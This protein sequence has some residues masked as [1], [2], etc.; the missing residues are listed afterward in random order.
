MI[1]LMTDRIIL[2]PPERRELT[3][4]SRNRGARLED[5]RRAR[6]VLGLASGSAGLRE[7]ARREGC[8]VNTV[9]TWRDRFMESRLPGLFSRHRGRK[10]E[11]GSEKIEARIIDWTLHRKP[12]DGSTQWSSRKLATALGLNHVR[13]ARVWGKAGLQ[14][15]RRRH[16]MASDDPN[17]EAKAA[18]II[19]LYLKPPAH[20]AVFC[21][22]EKTAIQA[23]DRLD[24][25]LPLSPGRAERHGFEY[26]RHGT[27]SL[28]AALETA[29]GEVLGRTASRHTSMEFVEFLREVVAGVE[30]GKAIH[31]IADNLSAHKTK[32]VAAFL[33]AHP[34][35]TIH[36][37][38]T[39]SSWLNQ[40]EIWFSKIQRDLISRG[41]FS[42][43]ADLRRKIMRYIRHYNK[44]ALPF[45]WTYRNTSKRIR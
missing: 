33:Q 40:V 28:Y 22:D 42:S 41:I 8:S 24:P 19:G 17:F 18:D 6:I 2:S 34:K 38:P 23:L 13:V 45:Q 25:V 11:E 26:Y 7:I 16:Y 30:P 10:V 27:L 3:R 21:V 35:V 9:S 15:H 43:K 29:T 1:P 14:P 32:A 12:A 4:M 44:S 20:A 31:I 36:Y 37:T 5:V 39:Y